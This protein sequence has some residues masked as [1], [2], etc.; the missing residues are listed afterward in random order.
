MQRVL[1]RVAAG[2]IGAL[3]LLVAAPGSASALGGTPVTIDCGDGFPI[4]ATVSLGRL[5]KLQAIL[6]DLVTYPSGTSCSL[7]QGTADPNGSTGMYAFGAGHYGASGCFFNF[8]FKGAYDRQG[9]LHGFQRVHGLESNPQDC[10]EAYFVADVTCLA[11]SG[12]QAEVRGVISEGDDGFGNGHDL[13]GQTGITD[14]QDSLQGTPDM[15]D[16]A[17]L[18]FGAQTACQAP[19]EFAA[20]EF[21]I[22]GHVEASST[23]S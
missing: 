15:V 4:S 8:S 16:E 1:S 14:G 10:G 7:T 11:V 5:T 21:A 18:P 19:G 12:N 17:Y 9:N 23:G 3:T 6:Q 20:F 2:L 13:D 22:D